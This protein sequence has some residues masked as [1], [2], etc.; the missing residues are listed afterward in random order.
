LNAG[1]NDGDQIK[2]L[3]N[4]DNGSFIVSDTITK[5]YGTGITV[6]TDNANSIASWTSSGNWGLTTEDYHSAPSSF[7]DSPGGD[8]GN[9]ITSSLIL[10]DTIDLTNALSANLNF[11]ARW[12]LE[13]GYDYVQVQAS[14]DFGAN[15]IPLC[16]QYTKLGNSSQDEGNPVFNGFQ[17][18]W[19]LEE[20]DLSD[21]LGEEILL[22]VRFKSDNFT[23]EDGFYFDDVELNIIEGENS[24]NPISEI[25]INKN[26]DVFPNPSNGNFTVSFNGTANEHFNLSIVDIL[27]KQ[28]GEAN[29]IRGGSSTNIQ[30]HKDKGVYFIVVKNAKNIVVGKQ[31]IV[32]E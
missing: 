15:W 23:T 10:N 12:E 32:L 26:I 8:H 21:F 18:E 29:H 31:R 19:V 25:E 1:V 3:L 30:L 4:I 6:F 22:R 11:W 5:T 13:T 16:G 9:N 7:T 2:F 17:F 27:G 24:E 28:I 20:M 14:N